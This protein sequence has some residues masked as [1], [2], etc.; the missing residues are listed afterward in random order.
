MRDPEDDLA[1]LPAL[2]R[3]DAAR[4][5]ERV[6]TAGLNREEAPCM[7]GYLR[8]REVGDRFI[9]DL[10]GSRQSDCVVAQAR[11]EH[12]GNAVMAAPGGGGDCGDGL[13][14][15]L[16][17]HGH[18]PS[19]CRPDLPMMTGRGGGG[20]VT[21]APRIFKKLQRGRQPGFAG[22]PHVRDSI[23]LDYGFAYFATKL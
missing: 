5:H 4:Q 10:D 16:E 11:S 6:A 1:H 7:S 22:E 3:V 21:D 18:G 14:E 23:A 17:T 19:P 20:F 9:D 13:A 8:Y 15:R 12:D 2:V